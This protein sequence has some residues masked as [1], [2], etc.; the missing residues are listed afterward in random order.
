MKQ[1]I[2][3]RYFVRSLILCILIFNFVQATWLY[4]RDITISSTGSSL[5]D[6]Q[7]L[8]TLNSSNFSYDKSTGEDGRD[9]RFSTVNSGNITPDIDYWIEEWNEN[10]TSKIWIN[11]PSVPASGDTTVYLYYG[12][13]SASSESDGFNT[14]EIF[15]DFEDGNDNG[16]TVSAGTWNV[17]SESD[18]YVYQTTTGSSN[19]TSYINSPTFSDL[20]YEADVNTVSTTHGYGNGA[21]VFR[22]NIKAEYDPAIN[23]V[24]FHQPGVGDIGSGAYYYS[25]INVWYKLKVK[26]GGSSLQL[27]INDANVLNVS[28]SAGTIPGT[29]GMIVWEANAKYDNLRIRKYASTEPSTSVGSEVSGDFP[30]PVTI[31]SVDVFLKKGNVQLEWITESET[32]NAHFLIYRNDKVIAC[33]DGAGTTTEPHDYSFTDNTVVPG[34]SYTYI[35][36]DISYANKEVKHTDEAV[37]ISIPENDIPQEFALDA[38]YPN[39]FNPRTAISFKL[40]AISNVELSIY[41]MSGKKIATL[42]N[43]NMPAGYYERNWDASDFSSGIYFYRL[44]AGDFVNTK[45][46]VLMK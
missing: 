24:K 37:T 11:V 45:K 29:I 46:M 3:V 15:D 19:S 42:V 30:C 35:L 38:N 31:S 7:V 10:G 16:W 21:L 20:I 14:F 6:F 39:P 9:I 4:R 32:D 1:S 36:A 18:N 25:D 5:S 8:V 22:N 12:N 13:S 41:D 27:Y 34:A 33:I 2:C 17:V 44:Q 28:S 26:V 23:N 43:D 40:S